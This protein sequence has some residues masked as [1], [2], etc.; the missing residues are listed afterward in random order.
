MKQ[1]NQKKI[2]NM[3]E[4]KDFTYD[5]TN[6]MKKKYFGEPIQDILVKY[7]VS[8]HQFSSCFNIT[9]E[10]V[11][12][13]FNSLLEENEYVGFNEPT[14]QLIFIINK[15]DDEVKDCICFILNTLSYAVDNIKPFN[16]NILILDIRKYENKY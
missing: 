12:S 14:N 15:N 10:Q 4:I 3:E 5:F 6:L 7:Y 13:V 16:E 2:N 8:T 1:S 11:L 9:M